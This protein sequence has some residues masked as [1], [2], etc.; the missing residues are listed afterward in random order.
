MMNQAEKREFGADA[1]I[2]QPPILPPSF[3]E[4]DIGAQDLGSVFQ[5][6]GRPN[7]HQSSENN[8]LNFLFGGLTGNFNNDTNNGNATQ[9]I[10][11]LPIDF[12]DFN[13]KFKD[14]KK[15]NQHQIPPQPKTFKSF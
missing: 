4:T 10:M 13:N 14:E 2:E 9:A 8:D 15:Q 5:M 12:G 3:F 11:A 6:L 7:N 1:G